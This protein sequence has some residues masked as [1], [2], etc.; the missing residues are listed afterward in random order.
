MKNTSDNPLR[1]IIFFAAATCFGAV[2]LYVP[3]FL[4]IGAAGVQE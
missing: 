2:V 1:K 3:V 4:S